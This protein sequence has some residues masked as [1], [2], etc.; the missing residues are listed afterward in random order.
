MTKEETILKM[1]ELGASKTPFLFIIDFEMEK[2]IVEKLDELNNDDI[3]FFFN[4]YSNVE[5]TKTEK[6][7]VLN[8]FPPNYSEYLKS[9]EIVKEN[10][11]L[12][13]SYLVNLTFSSEIKINANLESIFYQSKAKYKLFY[14][15]KFTF[16]SP[17]IFVKIIDGEIYSYPMKGTI[18]ASIFDAEN[19]ILNDEK[20]IAE[21]YTIVDLIRNDLN[22]VAKN[23][24]VEKFRYVDCISTNK[25][26]ILQLSSEITGDL[27][28]NYNKK[29]GN[30]IFSLLPAGSISGAPKK[31]TLEIIKHAE[32]SKRGFYTG[33]AGI[34]DGNNVDS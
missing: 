21:H 20:E 5:N 13:N 1:N 30:I 25:K 15:D 34:F 22:I 4:N 24:R 32:K 6:N 8:V 7:I 27:D 26:N 3:K 10:I 29:L 11:L 33:V 9:F 19:I 18:D 16:F 12:G 28:E 23:I 31:K 14:K 2:C 17:E